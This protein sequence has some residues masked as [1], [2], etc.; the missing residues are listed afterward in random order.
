MRILVS[1]APESCNTV[2]EAKEKPFDV[3]SRV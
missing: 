3:T 1:G 2:H